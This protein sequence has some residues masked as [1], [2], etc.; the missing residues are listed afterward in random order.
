[1]DCEGS[2]LV[3]L[4]VDWIPCRAAASYRHLLCK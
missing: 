1:M 2:K 3:E 4:A